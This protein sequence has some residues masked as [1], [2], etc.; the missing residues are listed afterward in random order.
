[1]SAL[2]EEKRKLEAER[3]ESLNRL[4]QIEKKLDKA[5][6]TTKLLDSDE[7][8]GDGD[9]DD[10]H[11]VVKKAA[12]R[13]PMYARVPMPIKKKRSVVEIERI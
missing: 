3:N 7:S 4:H 1:M 5:E 13:N 9:S 11:M 10:N 8:S 12:S 2:Q 6:K